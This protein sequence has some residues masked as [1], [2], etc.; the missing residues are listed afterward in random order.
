[1]NTNA[2]TTPMGMARATAASWLMPLVTAKA[3]AKAVAVAGSEE[4]EP[5]MLTA[6]M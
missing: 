6:P 1:M 5:P 2:A 3:T 4:M